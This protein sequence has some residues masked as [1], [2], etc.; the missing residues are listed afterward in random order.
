[1]IH[2]VVKAIWQNLRAPPSLEGGEEEEVK[3]LVAA[4]LMV[5]VPLAESGCSLGSG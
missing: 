3:T 4:L 2:L 5:C 1:M